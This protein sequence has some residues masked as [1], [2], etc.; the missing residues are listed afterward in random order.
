MQKFRQLLLLFTFISI[1]SFGQ[2]R[3]RPALCYDE[4]EVIFAPLFGMKSKVPKGWT[5]VL[6]RDTEVFLLMPNSGDGEIYVMG[7]SVNYEI[8]KQRWIEGL[9]LGNG[10]TL[11]SDGNIYKRGD[12][13]ASVA[14]LKNKTTG[15]KAFIEARCSKYDRCVG[16][17]LVISPQHYEEQKKSL[18]EFMNNIMFE[19]P[20]TVSIY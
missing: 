10:N 2:E 8:M 13:I 18:E 5:G 16:G 17:L 1:Q 14:I 6:P 20:S 12:G 15:S 3:L 7:D 4:G 9:D 11:L 19:E